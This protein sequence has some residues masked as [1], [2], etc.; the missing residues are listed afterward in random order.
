MCLESLHRI[1]HMHKT[2]TAG[3]HS[4]EQVSRELLSTR[5]RFAKRFE[6]DVE[7]ECMC[8]MQQQGYMLPGLYDDEPGDLKVQNSGVTVCR[9]NKGSLEQIFRYLSN[10]MT[11]L[12]S[13]HSGCPLSEVAAEFPSTAFH[14]IEI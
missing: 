2:F 4:F 10:L 1:M 11:L 7:F 14:S 6:R 8:D 9:E 3:H 5:S 13:D 12:N